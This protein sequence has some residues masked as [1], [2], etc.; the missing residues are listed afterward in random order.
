MAKLYRRTRFIDQWD[1]Y[2]GLDR[3]QWDALN[4]GEEVELAEVPSAAKEYLEECKTK[5]KES[6]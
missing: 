1:S 2:K 4:R 5:K 6:K 3:D